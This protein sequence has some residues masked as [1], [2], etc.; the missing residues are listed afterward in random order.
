MMH[1]EIIVGGLPVL[2]TK[3]KTLKNIYIRVYPPEGKVTVSAP[4]NADDEYLRMFILKKIPEIT[5][6]RDRMRSQERQSE[7]E[8]VSGESY[9]LWGKPYRL[10]VMIGGKYKDIKK[11]PSKIV[12]TLPAEIDDDARQ[13]LINEWYRA[14]LRRVLDTIVEKCEKKTGIKANEYRIKNMKTRWGTCNIDKARIWI[15]LQLAKKPMECLEY[16]VIHELIHLREK[17]HTH[18]FQEMV[19]EACPNWKEAKNLLSSLP[20]E[21]MRVD[22]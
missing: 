16:I 9:Y 11:T 22:E 14:E 10:Q 2:I 17:N 5:K 20:L 3:K 1:D 7:R 13:K 19:K 21:Y 4:E 8:Y 12:M 6:V 15:N 18:R